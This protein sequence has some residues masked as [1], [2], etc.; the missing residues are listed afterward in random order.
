MVLN[1][2]KVSITFRIKFNEI[3]RN[4]LASEIALRRKQQL[5]PLKDIPQRYN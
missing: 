4:Q 2:D 3:Y 1:L 5:N